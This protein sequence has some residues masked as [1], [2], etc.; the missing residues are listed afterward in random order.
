LEHAEKII[1]GGRLLQKALNSARIGT[2]HWDVTDDLVTINEA[3]ADILGY[4][5]HELCPFN[6]NRWLSFVHPEDRKLIVEKFVQLK[7]HKTTQFL[8]KCRFLHKN[9][10]WGYV[11]INGE[12]SEINPLGNPLAIGGI[13]K[14]ITELYYS[15]KTLLDRYKIE[16]LVSDISSDFAGIHTDDIDF[17]INQSLKKIGNTLKA[18]RC[19]VFQFRRNN[20]RMDNTHEWCDKQV[21][22]EI[23]N[24]QNLP[25]SLFPW[26]MKKMGK[27]EHIY[28]HRVDDLPEKASAE[29]EILLN[30][31]IKSLLVAPVHFRK[32]LIGFIGLDSVKEEKEWQEADVY[33][34]RNVAN[35][36]ANAFNA[37]IH[38][39]ILA[40]TMQKAGE[41][42][43]AKSSFL[44][45][46]NHELRTPLHHILG[47]SD[48]L[49]ANKIPVPEIA[50]FADKIYTS[51]KK[52]L[53]II[54]DILYLSFGDEP[55][56]KIREE[57]F[58]GTDLF[59]QHKGFL[60]EMLALSNIEK[61]VGLKFAPSDDFIQNQFI[62]DVNKINQVVVNLMKNAIKFTKNGS[63][64]YI[65]EV[66]NGML[67][68]RIKDSGIGIPEHQQELI[69]DFFRQVDD[70]S[71]R[72]YNG[73]GIGLTISRKITKILNGRLS[74]ISIPDKGTTFTFEVPVKQFDP[75]LHA[76]HLDPN[77]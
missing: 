4:G 60:E 30:Q 66:N 3:F 47:F 69:F 27:H 67:I 12:T 24:L 55:Y 14:D 75:L 15:K 33:M 25:T 16:K 44:A 6:I 71:T 5:L 31:S 8:L 52:L 23:N 40:K 35:T 48:L 77:S 29:R 37:R 74:V 49:R 70:S 57:H 72:I 42:D 68:F 43:L 20:S 22:P 1:S 10:G 62:S 46:V 19:Y 50:S 58:K 41:S 73:I 53:H 63:I 28:I 39:E 34:L 2:W 17:T 18:D 21:R 59:I 54:E 56:V 64:E 51:G 7:Q 38:H 76:V 36:V 13:M 9:G 45:T 65:V 11:Q 26:W 32:N 61:S